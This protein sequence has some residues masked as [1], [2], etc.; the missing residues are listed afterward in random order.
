MIY[1][2]AHLGN[3]AL[4]KYFSIRDE[5]IELHLRMKTRMRSKVERIKLGRDNQIHHRNMFSQCPRL[6]QVKLKAEFGVL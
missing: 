3:M 5:Q 4:E 6:A 2:V 1:P